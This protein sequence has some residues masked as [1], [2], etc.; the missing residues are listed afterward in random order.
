MKLDEIGR[1]AL[2]VVERVRS[3]GMARKLDDLP[4]AHE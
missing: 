4:D 3:I 1:E 2:Y